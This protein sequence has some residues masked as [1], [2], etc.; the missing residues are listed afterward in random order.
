MVARSIVSALAIF[1]TLGSAMSPV[2]PNCAYGFRQMAEREASKPCPRPGVKRIRL[3]P[4][5]IANAELEPGAKQVLRFEAFC[6][7]SGQRVYIRQGAS[8]TYVTTAPDG[9]SLTVSTSVPVPVSSSRSPT[10]LNLILPD[11]TT[12]TFPSDAVLDSP[13]PCSL[14]IISPRAADPVPAW[15][16][17]P[18]DYVVP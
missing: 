16:T 10:G 9:T 17:R 18:P 12:Q 2:L 1:G 15:L 13:N 8:V 14:E 3:P 7:S 6:F 4:E 11:G 5:V